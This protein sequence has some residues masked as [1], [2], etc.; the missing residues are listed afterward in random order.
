V[1]QPAS[2]NFIVPLDTEI[3]LSYDVSE[4]NLHALEKIT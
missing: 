1:K 3:R 2:T 4:A